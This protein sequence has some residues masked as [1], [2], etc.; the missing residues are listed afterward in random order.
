MTALGIKKGDTG[1]GKKPMEP[2]WR[3]W[4]EYTE[5]KRPDI[6]PQ[7]GSLLH[8]V[9][10]KLIRVECKEIEQ[11]Q[12]SKWKSYAGMTIPFLQ[13]EFESV[14]DVN[15]QTSFYT[16]SINPV[17]PFGTFKQSGDSS[18]STGFDSMFNY[19]AHF[20]NI[21][22]GE[23]QELAFPL[24]DRVVDN[25]VFSL[26]LFQ[27]IDLNEIIDAFKTMFET[28][29]NVHFRDE[30]GNLKGAN[31]DLLIKLTVDEYNNQR[32][33]MPSFNPQGGTIELAFDPASGRRTTLE[34]NPVK[35]NIIPVP[36]N[37]TST[38]SAP[39]AVAGGAAAAAINNLAS[40]PQV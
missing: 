28:V 13:F 23:T 38:A 30:K 5:G 32:F 10:G 1:I 29:A 22:L 6:T 34:L 39:K 12:K 40:A 14:P 8:L 20:E 19:I 18:V 9:K 27:A 11:S 24:A 36:V 26:E 33:A 3:L 2:N 7:V 15:G 17:D 21:I 16:H 37:K 31:K 25:G 4:K 35:D